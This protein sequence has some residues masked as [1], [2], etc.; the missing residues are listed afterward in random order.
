MTELNQNDFRTP[1]RQRVP[2]SLLNKQ[3][4]SNKRLED[5]YAAKLVLAVGITQRLINQHIMPRV[6]GWIEKVQARRADTVH[7]DVDEFEIIGRQ[8]DR[9]RI[10]THEQTTPLAAAVRTAGTQAAIALSATNKDTTGP[11]LKRLLR[12]DPFA[13]E[14]FLRP[15]AR[16]W[17][18]QNVSLIKSIGGEHL[19]KVEQLINRM[20]RQGESIKTIRAELERQFNTTKNRA[21]LI[22]R[23]QVNKYNGQLTHERQVRAGITLYRWRNMQDR[24]VRGFPGGLYPKA[25][26]SHAVMDGLLLKWSD[27]SVYFDD[28]SKKWKLKTTLMEKVHPGQAIQC[29][30]FAQPVIDNV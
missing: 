16:D 22:A 6:A 24:R 28:R 23:D 15:L 1:P 30:C 18:A 8:F 3:P 25:V 21:R 20:V 27:A 13:N 10:N 14:P 29:R 26:P 7:T 11:V 12:V 17:V 5:T 9:L 2:V 4:R 19:G